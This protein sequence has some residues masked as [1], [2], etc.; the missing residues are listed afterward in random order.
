MVVV[1]ALVAVGGFSGSLLRFGVGLLLPGLVGTFV[2]NVVGSLV[3]GGLVGAFRGSDRLG[4]RSRLV[5]GAG[6]L[7]SFTTYSTFVVQSAGAGPALL[8]AN[9]LAT[10]AFGFAG[11]LL[12]LR[13]GQRVAGGSTGG[14]HA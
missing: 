8:V 2:V 3:L 12:G 5:A 10:Y 4:R 11:A 7:S 14:D 6:F 13:A 1:A 9:V